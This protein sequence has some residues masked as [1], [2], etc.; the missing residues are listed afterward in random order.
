MTCHDKAAAYVAHHSQVV[1]LEDGHAFFVDPI[2]LDGFDLTH[3]PPV[4]QAL[5]GWAFRAGQEI[6]WRDRLLDTIQQDLG[7][8][9]R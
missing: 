4:G 5:C 6:G 8:N 3:E 7:I 9:A 1:Y 2:P